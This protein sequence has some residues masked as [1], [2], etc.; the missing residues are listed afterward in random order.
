MSARARPA[1]AVCG[2]LQGCRQIGR[3]SMST[4]TKI[5][6][7]RSVVPPAWPCPTPAWTTQERLERIQTMTDR[8][9]GYVKFL[10]EVDDLKGIS[11]E[12]KKMAVL[13]FYER[14]IVLEHQLGRIQENLQLA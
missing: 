4:K 6:A 12:A 13:A 11:A 7:A 5:P 3:L 10:R 1:P 9:S 14:M 2:S 8:I